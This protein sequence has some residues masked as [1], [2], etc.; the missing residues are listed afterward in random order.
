MKRFLFLALV[1]VFSIMHFQG[2]EI[3]Y[4]KADLVVR[5]DRTAY[6]SEA[7]SVMRISTGIS[8]EIFMCQ[9]AAAMSST[10]HT[11]FN[12]I[13]QCEFMLLK[14]TFLWEMTLNTL[15]HYK[16]IRYMILTASKRLLLESSHGY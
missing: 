11:S 4:A 2:S 1:A 15:C 13:F 12:C 5:Y 16:Q 7:T 10:K 9:N 3:A 6:C 14:W 8:G